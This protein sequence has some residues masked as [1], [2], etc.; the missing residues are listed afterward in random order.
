MINHGPNGGGKIPGFETDRLT[1]GGFTGKSVPQ[2]VCF[3]FINFL[4]Q[5]PGNSGLVIV[6]ITPF[7]FR[8]PRFRI[9]AAEGVGV[10]SPVQAAIIGLLGLPTSCG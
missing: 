4:D 2:S 8:G 5:L 7:L 3:R 6:T 1:H 10:N 9:R